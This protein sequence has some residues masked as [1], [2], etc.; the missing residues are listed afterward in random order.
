MRWTIL[1]RQEDD[2]SADTVIPLATIDRDAQ[3]SI[4]ELGLMHQEGKRIL[5]CLQ[6]TLLQ[7]QCRAYLARLRSCPVC[8][9]T[10]HIKDYR[11]RRLQT[12]YG[13]I[14]L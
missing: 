11:K 4:A 5:H 1:I 8:G 7:Q 13:K 9:E 10:M 12:V 2:D 14:D 3:P 6:K